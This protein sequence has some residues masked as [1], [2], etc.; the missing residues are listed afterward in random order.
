M[1]DRE[2]HRAKLYYL[3]DADQREVD[4]IVTVD[5]KP[6]F[7]VEVKTQD[8][9][10]SSN[11]IYFKDKLKIPFSYQVIKKKGIDL[12]SGSVRVISADTFLAALI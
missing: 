11:L 10:A 7:S 6:W 3:R 1:H 8:D 12:F 4:F 5:E 2:G 9:N